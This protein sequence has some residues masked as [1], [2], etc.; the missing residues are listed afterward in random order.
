[1]LAL[2]ALALSLLLLLLLLLPLPQLRLLLL[3]AVVVPLMTPRL[4]PWLFSLLL[5]P[6]L[7]FILLT[8]FS[9]MPVCACTA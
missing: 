7:L 4:L 3:L 1:M 5:L 2:S 9:D 6:A 8:S